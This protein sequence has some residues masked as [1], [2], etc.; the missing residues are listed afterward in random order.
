MYHNK[1][2][3]EADVY[4]FA[5]EYK[6][7]SPFDDILARELV[8]CNFEEQRISYRFETKDWW[9]NE[10]GEI[11]GGM[12]CSMFDSAVGTVA[13]YAAGWNEATTTDLNFS[14]LRPLPGGTH[15]VVHTYIVKNGRTM[16][17]LRGEMICEETGKLIATATGSWLPLH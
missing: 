4:K 14:Y 1:K 9:Q 15:A 3:W 7:H 11:H 10:R 2:E 8:G 6:D 13:I 16:I 12:I 17:R 5:E